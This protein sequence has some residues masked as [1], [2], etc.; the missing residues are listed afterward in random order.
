MFGYEVFDADSGMRLMS[1]R[2]ADEI[3]P[4]VTFRG[5]SSSEIVIRAIAAGFRHGEVPI[6]YRQRAGESRGL[7]VANIASAITRVAHESSAPAQ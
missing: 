5:F 1:R 3:V 4:H 6:T 2:I 7:P